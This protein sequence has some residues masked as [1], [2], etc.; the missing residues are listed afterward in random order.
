MRVYMGLNWVDC[1]DCQPGTIQDI[2]GWESAFGRVAGIR[3]VVFE[4]KKRMA[5]E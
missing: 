4:I 2:W 5:G 1:F 3:A